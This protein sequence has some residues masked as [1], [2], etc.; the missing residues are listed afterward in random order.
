MQENLSMYAQFQEVLAPASQA[1]GAVA[2]PVIDGKGF[3][4]GGLIINVGAVAAGGSLQ[5]ALQDSPDG[6]NFT[7]VPGASFTIQAAGENKLY[8]GGFLMR[9]RNRYLQ[10]VATV[11]GA[12][13]V[14]GASMVFYYG[15]ERPV[16]PAE[17]V[18]FE[19]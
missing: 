7:A 13:V 11:A 19:V 1:P 18:M 8:V 9:N 12:A 15:K 3:D 6:V 4:V 16:T 2:T 14:F 10:V 17:T 5:I